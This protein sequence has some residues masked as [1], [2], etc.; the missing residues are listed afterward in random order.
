MQLGTADEADVLRARMLMITKFMELVNGSLTTQCNMVGSDFCHG[1]RC[2]IE[3]MSEATEQCEALQRRMAAAGLLAHLW[4]W[5]T[6]SSA[7]S[8]DF[9][10]SED[11]YI[12]E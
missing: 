1:P 5:A 6:S 7:T 10:T 4:L 11:P 2:Y 8:E 9:L 12:A 3:Q